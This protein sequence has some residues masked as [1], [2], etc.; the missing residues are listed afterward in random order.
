VEDGAAKEETA[1]RNEETYSGAG[2]GGP[3]KPDVLSRIQEANAARMPS[4][5]GAIL[6]FYLKRAEFPKALTFGE[7]K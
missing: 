7:K 3:Q 6:K 1:G 5:R 2:S 4:A